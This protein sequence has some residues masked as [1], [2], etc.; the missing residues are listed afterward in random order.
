MLA[1]LARPTKQTGVALMKSTHG[2]YKADLSLQAPPI[3]FQLCVGTENSD[4][5]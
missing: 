3:G 1:L 2:W 4:H 5:V